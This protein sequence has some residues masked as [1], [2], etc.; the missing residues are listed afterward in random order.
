MKWYVHPSTERLVATAT[1]EV[2]HS[3]MTSASPWRFINCFFF[4]V[5]SSFASAVPGKYPGSTT[6]TS[7]I[8]AS[9]L[10]VKRRRLRKYTNAHHQRTNSCPWITEKIKRPR[11]T[12]WLNRNEQAC[13]YDHKTNKGKFISTKL[14]YQQMHLLLKHKMLQFIFKIYF[15]L[16]LLHVSVPS[17]HHQ[18]QTTE[19]CQ[20]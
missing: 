1:F 2:C 13:F 7:R 17:D 12:A 3:E 14:F 18:G 6:I 20:S 4:W 19:P 10:F 8:L 9:K 15:L 5:S 11:D 16:W